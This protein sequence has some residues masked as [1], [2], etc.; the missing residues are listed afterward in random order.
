[1]APNMSIAM[2]VA[3]AFALFWA[4]NSHVA[5]A[6]QF[7]NAG[8]L[9][10][11]PIVEPVQMREERGGGGGGGGRSFGGGGGGGGGRSFG[12]GGGGGGG[13][14]FDGGGGGG[15]RSFG[16]GE[17][18]SF[19]GGGGGGER[20]SFGGGGGGVER[21]SFTGDRRS[22]GFDGFRRG[23]GDA[24]RIIRRGDGDS[25]RFMRRRGDNEPR[26]NGDG[27]G[28]RSLWRGGNRDRWTSRGDRDGRRFHRD[29][30]KRHHDRRRI[31]RLGR[32]LFWGSG[33]WYYDGYYYGNC[34]WLRRRALITGS[35]YWWRRYRLCRYWD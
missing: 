18:R 6:A 4:A 30:H 27:R 21:R 10:Q 3:G 14:S 23:D 26:F 11:A 5:S 24:G 34:E 8:L 1:M 7:P 33:F 20:R 9:D 15:G 17:R 12:G 28:P 2:P 16:G 19:G 32:H 35:R 25:R 31:R 13:R 22:R 29:R